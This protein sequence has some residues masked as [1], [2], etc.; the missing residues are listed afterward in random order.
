ML[1][2]RYMLS[3]LSTSLLFASAGI[4]GGQDYPNKPIRMVANAAGGSGDITA[5][6]IAQGMSGP[7]GQAIII[8]NR[9]SGQIQAEI[10]AKAPPDGYTLLVAGGSIIT[11]PLLK[12]T[13]YDV[14]ADFSPI[15][16][17]TR[18]PAVLVVYPSVPAKSVKELIA[19]AKAKPGELNY[20]S[21]QAGSSNHLAAEL[22]KSMAGVNIVH[23]AYNGTPQLL[24]A[25]ISGEVQ[26]SFPSVP[27]AMASIKSGRLRA[28]AVTSAQPTALAPG[29]PTVSGS[30][31]PGY[32][33]ASI[34][35][36]FAP[37]K[38]PELVIK[39]LNQ[40]IVRFLK[41]AEPREQL[42]NIGSETV[43]SS[44]EQLTT[45][46]KADMERLGKLIKDAGLK[47]D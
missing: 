15:T 35:A 4:V 47:L 42:F 29:L 26:L 7:L 32:E 22:F 8:D 16:L 40:E 3:M 39:R 19:L 30:G 28:L 11:L 2:S 38:T 44:P 36:L 1:I 6:L 17:A 24:G 12:K 23:V 37:A 9:P 33:S 21:G 34:T 25:A 41:T 31:V 5:R 13:S 46:V 18:E 45:A 20:S 43:G 27:S 10:V 14:L